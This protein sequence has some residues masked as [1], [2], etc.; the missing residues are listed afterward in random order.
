MVQ[1]APCRIYEYARCRRSHALKRI[2]ICAGNWSIFPHLNITICFLTNWGDLNVSWGWVITG[3]FPNLTMATRTSDCAPRGSFVIFCRLGEEKLP[4]L[5][6]MDST[7]DK[8]PRLHLGP[9]NQI[10]CDCG[11]SSLVTVHAFFDD[12]GKIPLAWNEDHSSK[13]EIRLPS[14]GLAWFKLSRLKI[15]LWMW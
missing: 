14:T 10:S 12:R 1:Q 3:W 11:E 5:P 6:L 2:A 15:S 7:K 13:P 4:Y 8:L 9:T